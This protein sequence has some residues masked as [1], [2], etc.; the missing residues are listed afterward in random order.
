MNI[1]PNDIRIIDTQDPSGKWLGAIGLRK[2]VGQKKRVYTASVARSV[3]GR[4]V[5]M[6]GEGPTLKDALDDA[7]ARL[8]EYM[9]NLKKSKRALE[10]SRAIE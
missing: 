3:D 8:D 1:K 4:L 6:E 9:E 7:Q 10:I 2:L 5:P